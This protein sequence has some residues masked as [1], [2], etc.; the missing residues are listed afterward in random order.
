MVYLLLLLYSLI[1]IKIKIKFLF[2]HTVFVLSNTF[3]DSEYRMR[4]IEVMMNGQYF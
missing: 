3:T 1:V 2:L 4:G